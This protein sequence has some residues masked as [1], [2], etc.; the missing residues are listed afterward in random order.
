[1]K[2]VLTDLYVKALRPAP[3]G[4]RVVTWDAGLQS[5]SATPT[6]VSARFS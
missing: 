1:M 5:L 6:V 3:S 2:H 4:K